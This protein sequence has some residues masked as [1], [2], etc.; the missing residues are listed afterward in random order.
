MCPINATLSVL[1]MAEILLSGGLQLNEIRNIDG[2]GNNELNNEMG[3]KN[4]ETR[5][6][7]AADYSDGYNSLAGSNRPNPRGILCDDINIWI[8]P[9]GR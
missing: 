7:L 8:I 3:A 9:M 4:A 1:A 6:C 2:T 5:R